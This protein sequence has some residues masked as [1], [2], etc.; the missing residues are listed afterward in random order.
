MGI[1]RRL[2]RPI[3]GI[4]IAACLFSSVLLFQ[5]GESRTVF[6]GQQ[7]QWSEQERLGSQS[8]RIDA[9]KDRDDRIEKHLD[10]NDVRLDGLSDKTSAIT[11]VGGTAVAVIGILA[12]LG[13]ISKPRHHVE[14]PKQEVG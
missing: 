5:I 4:F 9:L 7:Q 8:A 1:I 2:H 12:G 10:S 14:I 6:A 11:G 3:H 13:F